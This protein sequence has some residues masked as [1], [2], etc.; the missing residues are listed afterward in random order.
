MRRLLYLPL[1]VI[2]LFA[3][4]RNEVPDVQ[5]ETPST[6]AKV[7][8][9]ISVTDFLSREE[10]LRKARENQNTGAR[11]D[12]ATI[13]HLYY[14]A[15]DSAGRQ[16][17]S[18][19]QTPERNPNDFGIISDSLQPG[20]YTI[21]LV[22]SETLL[23]DLP[24][25]SGPNI[26]GFITRRYITDPLGQIFVKKMQ[27]TVD[28]TPNPPKLEVAL[29][30]I[31]GEVMVEITDAPPASDSNFEI[32]VKVT[33]APPSYYLDTETA[34]EPEDHNTSTN[35]DRIDQTHFQQYIFGS[36]SDLKVIITYY[37]KTTGT[38]E[39]TKTIE[40]VKCHANKKTIITGRLFEAPQPNK[41]GLNIKIDQSWDTDR[42]VIYF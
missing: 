39:L 20:T 6:I 33:N 37:N 16:L 12:S 15:Y 35:S 28:T 38:V 18:R 32:F 42:T 24:L 13:E 7:P 25:F 36:D 40:H 23:H 2:T 31:V 14:I 41:P 11:E 29:N 3:C 5:T 30:R 27:L 22:A 26:Y 4:K 9:T 8:I 10:N 34:H 17:R 21:I 1:F 19:S